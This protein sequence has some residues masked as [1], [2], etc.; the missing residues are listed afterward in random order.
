MTDSPAGALRKILLALLS[1]GILV[2]TIDLLLLQHYEDVWQLAPLGLNGVGIMVIACYLL[3]GGRR[4]LRFMQGTMVL[5]VLAGAA[6]IVLHFQGNMEFQLD[7][8]PSLSTW[9]LFWKVLRSKAP[10]ALAPASMAQLGLLGLI[11]CYRHP[12]LSRGQ[13]DRKG[14]EE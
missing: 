1:L 12:A 7:I 6:G 13:I 8:D 2:T 5:F 11:F 3:I 4:S 10:P 9:D 14:T